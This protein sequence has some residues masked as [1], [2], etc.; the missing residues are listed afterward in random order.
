MRRLYWFELSGPW[1]L[2]GYALVLARDRGH[3]RRLVVKQL[4]A[5]P[6]SVQYDLL[7]KNKNLPLKNFKPVDMDETGVKMFYN[8]DY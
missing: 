2:N 7:K 1:G 5:D 3:A 6:I 4:E 8:G